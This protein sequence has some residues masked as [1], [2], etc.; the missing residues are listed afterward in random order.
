MKTSKDYTVNFRE[1]GEITVP[2]G[3]RLTNQ[4]ACGI[5]KDYHF[6]DDF[7]WVEPHENGVKNYALIHDLIYYG[8][9][10]PKEFVEMKHC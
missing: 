8:L 4:T 1:H 9:N 6:V 5:D 10:V 2:K 7:S 3:T